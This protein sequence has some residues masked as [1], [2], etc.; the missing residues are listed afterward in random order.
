MTLP[1]LDTKSDLCVRWRNR[2]PGQAT[3]AGMGVNGVRLESQH[4]VLCRRE[5][6]IQGEPVR[7]RLGVLDATTDFET[8][9][10]YF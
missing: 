3:C 6:E 5:P 2:K 7:R 8:L 9:A 1:D 4:T 10:H